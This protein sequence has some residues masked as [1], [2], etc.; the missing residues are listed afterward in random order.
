MR[1]LAASP[2]AAAMA[3]MDFASGATVA[4]SPADA[5]DIFDLKAAAEDNIPV[6]H[7]GYLVTGVND[8]ETLRANRT[9]FEKYYVRSK[10][11]V[12]VADVDM[13]VEI[14]GTRWPTPIILA[15]LASQR[16]MVAGDAYC[17]SKTS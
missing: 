6:A 3:G 4:M 14:L 12:S 16:E 17:R 1:Y 5:I 8:E 13:S 11:L 9:A 7:W 2:V 10:R 15:P